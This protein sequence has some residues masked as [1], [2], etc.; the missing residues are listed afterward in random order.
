MTAFAKRRGHLS[1]CV[2]MQ[3]IF[4][5]HG[6]PMRMGHCSVR[7]PGRATS[8]STST[9]TYS[10]PYLRAPKSKGLRAR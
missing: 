3:I 8:R 1:T 4:S 7:A 10:A 9:F 6:W 5:T 2:P